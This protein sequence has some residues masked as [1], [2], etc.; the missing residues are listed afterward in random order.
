MSRSWQSDVQLKYETN[1]AA[2]TALS[3]I[4]NSFYFEYRSPIRLRNNFINPIQSEMNIFVPKSERIGFGSDLHTSNT[5]IQNSPDLHELFSRFSHLKSLLFYNFSKYQLLK[6]LRF[7][8]YISDT[9]RTLV[10]VYIACFIH[11]HNFYEHSRNFA[12]V[13]YKFWKICKI[14]LRELTWCL[15]M[16]QFAQTFLTNPSKLRI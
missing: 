15:T 6:S 2:T 12:S 5:H 3:W 13:N 7:I 14:S 10:F 11:Y 4:I 9:R 1:N 16:S 8:S